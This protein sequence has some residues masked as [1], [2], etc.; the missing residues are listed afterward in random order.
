MPSGSAARPSTTTAVSAVPSG[1]SSGLQR[2]TGHYRVPRAGGPR[3]F[4]GQ[5]RLESRCGRLRIAVV[6]WGAGASLDTVKFNDPIVGFIFGN[7]GLMFNL[8]LEG[9]KYTRL[10]R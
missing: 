9:S 4:P 5:Q 3:Q 7:E 10:V 2:R 1:C 6:E 8:S